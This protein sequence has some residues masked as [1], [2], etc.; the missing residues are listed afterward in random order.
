MNIKDQNEK[1]RKNHRYRQSVSK[2]E[3]PVNNFNNVYDAEKNKIESEKRAIS[4]DAES[5]SL[6][7]IGEG[8]F[9]TQAE[10]LDF[11]QGADS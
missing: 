10:I 11:S 2:T 3:M 8:L 9:L 5:D 7:D 6:V 1:K 4:D